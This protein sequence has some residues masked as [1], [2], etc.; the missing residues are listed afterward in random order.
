MDGLTTK[1]PQSE[2]VKLDREIEYYNKK[3]SENGRTTKREM[4][5]ND[6]LKLLVEQLKHQ[7]PTNPMKDREFIAQMAQISSLEQM[8]N[9]SQ[10]FDE[11]NDVMLRGQAFDLLGK[12]VE[13]EGLSGSV[14]GTVSQVTG[15]NYP[16]VLV[17]N[18]YYD[19]DQV[20]RVIHGGANK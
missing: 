17:D 8:N 1:M 7:D 13:I 16:Q 18:T 12:T 15:H 20:T 4:G 3:I 5:K 10:R 6:F 2:V 19:F 11:L 9:M 14:K